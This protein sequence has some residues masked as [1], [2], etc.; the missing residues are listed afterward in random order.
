MINN[1]FIVFILLL[2]NEDGLFNAL[3]EAKRLTM[4]IYQVL[5]RIGILMR[6]WE[7]FKLGL[8]LKMIV[9]MIIL[10]VMVLFMY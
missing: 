2:K 7:L 5:D 8:G 1:N 6:R 9:M 10:M 4:K 3:Y